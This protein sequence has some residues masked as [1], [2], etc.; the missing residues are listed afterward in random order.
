[1]AD[2]RA[3]RP[4][5]SLASLLPSSTSPA[6][7]AGDPRQALL[8]SVRHPAAVLE[9]DGR[10]AL[11]NR[12]WLRGGADPAICPVGTE[13]TVFAA[14]LERTEPLLAGLS[15]GLRGVLARHADTYAVE[16]AAGDRWTELQ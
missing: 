6:A 12:A 5:R 9:A 7:R 15:D 11:T 1:M 10:V 13:F 3:K 14:E 8:D 2:E 4:V 16:Y